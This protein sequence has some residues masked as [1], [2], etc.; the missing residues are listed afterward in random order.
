MWIKNDN[1]IINSKNI[2]CFNIVE[3]PEEIKANI[4]DYD[5]IRDF[6]TSAYLSG[7]CYLF[8]IDCHSVPIAI[9]WYDSASDAEKTL[10]DI[11]ENLNA[12]KASYTVSS[13]A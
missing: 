6:N 3:D 2:G 8:A 9:G 11:Y 10:E 12:G 5:T 13:P 1:C 7:K 4:K